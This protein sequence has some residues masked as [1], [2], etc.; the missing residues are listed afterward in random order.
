MTIP[1]LIFNFFLKKNI[2]IFLRIFLEQI[3]WL[4]WSKLL[5]VVET[6]ETHLDHTSEYSIAS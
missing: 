2:I 6:D 4:K 3:F 1:Y 5:R